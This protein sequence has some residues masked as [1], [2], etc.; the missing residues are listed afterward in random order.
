M[1]G[2]II[3]G[4]RGYWRQFLPAGRHSLAGFG[5]AV[6]VGLICGVLNTVYA[7]SYVGLAFPG[8]LAGGLGPALGVGLLSTALVSIAV[9]LVWRFPGSMGVISPEATLV[10]GTTGL[11]FVAAVAPEQ[12]LA[13]LMATVAL[14]ALALGVLLLVLARARLGYL[15]HYL[16][17]PVVAGLIAGLGI[18]IVIGGLELAAPDLVATAQP[19]L[20]TPPGALLATAGFGA[21]CWLVQYR[22]PGMLNLPLLVGAATLA[23]WLTPGAMDRTDWLLHGFDATT[24]TLPGD[25]WRNL[26]GVDWTAIGSA[27]LTLAMLVAFL[28][29]VVLAD[30]ATMETVLGRHLEPNGTLRTFGLANLAS[31]AIGGFPCVMNLSGTSL[32]HRCRSSCRTV[33]VIAGVVPLAFCWLGPQALAV[34]P[35]FVV[36]GIV[37]YVGLEFV[38]EWLILLWRRLGAADRAI[39]VAVVASVSLAGFAEGF[40]LGLL[41]GVVFFVVRSSALPVIRHETTARYRFSHVDRPER[42]QSL[43]RQEGDGTLV[44]ELGG[45]LFFGSAWR[46]LERVRRRTEADPPLRGLLLDFRRV[47]GVDSSGWHNFRKIVDLGHQDRFRVVLSQLPA[48]LEQAVR[49]EGIVDPRH[50]QVRLVPDMDRGLELLEEET[51]AALPCGLSEAPAVFV[52]AASE[53]AL[54]EGLGSYAERRSFAPGEPLIRQGDASEDVFIVR[55]GWIAIVIDGPG[56]EKIRLRRAGPGTVVGEIAFILRRPRTA[57]AVADTAVTADRLTAAAIARMAEEDPLLL[58]RLQRALLRILARR[59]SD[60]T[61]LLLQLSR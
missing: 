20:S 35:A 5:G 61:E 53:P 21:L 41:L 19:T 57:W 54:I 16:P 23:F 49:L 43:L 36:G 60:S 56:G 50:V 13:T 2:T 38:A 44:L 8:P 3:T 28:A 15:M 24:T 34:L 39:L 12:Q 29:V 52:D 26:G 42:D 40:V 18:L 10:I 7:L 37:V 11:Q 32:A 47:T 48:A 4:A 59:L 51:L 14:V 45:F 46:I 55:S 25:V 9:A 30:S 22:W 27:S 1:R 58:V 31:G 33:G 6:L 17:F